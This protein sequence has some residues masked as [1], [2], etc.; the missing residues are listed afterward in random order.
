[1]LAPD[2]FREPVIRAVNTIT[3]ALENLPGVESVDSLTNI[4]EIYGEADTFEVRKLVPQLPLLEEEAAE[5]R[6]R[7]TEGVLYRD[8]LVSER[9][10][11]TAIIVFP[12]DDSGVTSDKLVRMIEDVVSEYEDAPFRVVLGGPTVTA[13]AFARSREKC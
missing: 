2:V 7:A 9:G 5:I 13:A 8:R 11:A 3:K 10:D 4:D 6:K 12:D 1:M